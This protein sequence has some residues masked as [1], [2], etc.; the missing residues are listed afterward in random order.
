MTYRFDVEKLTELLQYFYTISKITMSVWD[1]D[2][3][4]LTFYPKP[5]SPICTKIKSCTEGKKRC[6]D[7]DIDA[8]KVA[9]STKAP[10]TF[11]CHA[12]LVDTVVPIFHNDN[13]I[14]YIM[15]GQIRDQEQTLS[16]IENV[17][18]LCKRY[19]VAEATI[20]QYYKDL[21]ILDRKQIDALSNLFKMCIPYFYTS[22][23]I[24]IEQNELATEIE[25]YINQNIASSLSIN[26]LCDKFRIS[27]N[28]LYQISHNFFGTSIKDYIIQKKIE[29]S[30]HYLTTTQMSISE[31]SAKVGF[32]DYNYYIRTFKMRVGY[33]PLS[34]RKNF[35]LN[36]L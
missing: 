12:G 5:M 24:K 3:N 25:D 7:S 33:T 17:K 9:S 22:H 16:N 6:L 27:V 36:I 18:I 2:F 21:P 23:A 31:I 8:C 11:T 20:E 13:L 10:Y 29:K 34:Y 26:E 35:P 32:T 30:K 14:A 28:L 19:D 15:F 1:S 4:Q